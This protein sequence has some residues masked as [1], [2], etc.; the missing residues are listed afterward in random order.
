MPRSRQ[1]TAPR[2]VNILEKIRYARDKRLVVTVSTRS[3]CREAVI[4][5]EA[6]PWTALAKSGLR[7][8]LAG[9]GHVVRN[10]ENRQSVGNS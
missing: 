10:G 2:P 5:E 4:S 8:W 3:S 6:E 1:V 9:T 7:P